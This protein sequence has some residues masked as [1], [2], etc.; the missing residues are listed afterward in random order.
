MQHVKIGF[1]PS[2]RESFGDDWAARMRARCIEQ[3][4]RVPG[5][6]LVVP[7][8]SLTRRGLVYS[9]EEGE[10]ARDL[11]LRE[12]V[13]GVI[14]GGMTF[15]HE[16]SA[17]GVVIAGLPPGTPVLQ[18]ATK[19]APMSEGGTRP[20]DSWCGQFAIT[21]ALRRRAIRFQHIPTCF[22][23]EPVFAREAARFV[24][25][26]AAVQGFR[27]ARFGQ[28]GTRPEEF[29]SVWWDEASL[30]KSFNQTVVPVD[31]A[32]MFARMEA[33]GAEAKETQDLMEEMSTGVDAGAIPRHCLSNLARAEIALRQLARE[34]HLVGMGVNCWTQ[35]QQRFGI[36]VCS[37]LGR[38]TDS[39]LM[40]SCEVDI[41]G[42]ATMW[43]AYL[44]SLGR[45]A[46]HLIDWT[47]LHPDRENVFLAWHCGN[48]PPSLCDSG[49]TPRFLP[50]PFL[51]PDLYWGT[52]HMRLRPGPVTC[53][54]LVEYDGEFSMFIGQGE[55]QNIDPETHGTYGWV[56]VEDVMDWEQVMVEKGIIHHGV[57]IHDPEV[58]PALESFCHFLD[59]EVIKAS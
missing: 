50:Q 15:G 32:E 16:T 51:P 8:E 22:P 28:I 1:I 13:A 21:S 2:H 53:A 7:D 43:A 19:A 41:Y 17:V 24:R 48:A 56:R 40:A 29:E 4:K 45:V 3:F 39:G 26:C 47:E 46:P 57:L 10:R 25:A 35:V 52:L 58:G 37:V 30:Q 54:R 23:E 38:L 33:V 36:C 11:F 18:F 5:L 12:Q 42:A 27:G 49:C 9:L 14:V 55:V 59:I 20:S 44:A 34:K 31:L 6:D